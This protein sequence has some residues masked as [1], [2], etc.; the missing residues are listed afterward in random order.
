MA[1]AG[2]LSAQVGFGEEVTPGTAVT[3]TRFA[4]LVSESVKAP[5]ERIESQGLRT[6]RKT[7]D[8]WV[9]G[10]RDVAGDLDMEVMPNGFGLPT[11]H[12][13]GTVATAQPDAVNSPTVYE[14][15][16]KVGALDGKALTMQFGRT[17]SDGVTRA[18][19]YAGC[20]IAEWELSC[21]IDGLLAVKLTLDGVSETT[22]TALAAASYPATLDPL[23]FTGASITIA[24]TTYDVGN[25]S[26]KGVNSLKRDRKRLGS[27]SKLE[28]LEGAGFR[29]YTGQLELESFKDLTAYN[30][31][32][33]G[34]EA[35]LVANFTG[36]TIEDAFK[37]AVEIRCIR[38]R[39]DGETP[40]IDGPD[41]IGQPLPFKALYTANA[42]TEVQILTRN[43][44]STA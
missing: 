43:T 35:E 3:V 9:E 6:G 30:L 10:F 28:Q 12:M 38:C 4:E 14:H 24:G 44:D 41:L 34:T 19:T 13:L 31:F 36:G 39:F 7:V 2:G 5:R 11:K 26:L 42:Q 29:D 18:F 22:A 21:A 32:V 27:N 8:N 23:A 16:A 15:T 20:K 33:N 17:G 25:F 37:Y 1:V 40:G